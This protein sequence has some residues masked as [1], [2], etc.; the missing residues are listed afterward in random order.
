M[1]NVRQKYIFLLGWV[2]GAGS[3]C[4]NPYKDRPGVLSHARLPQ[5]S[6]W[7][8]FA[9]AASEFH[10]A[11]CLPMHSGSTWL[12]QTFR[13]SGNTRRALHLRL[14]SVVRRDGESRGTWI[15]LLAVSNRSFAWLP[16]RIARDDAMKS[17]RAQPPSKSMM[18]S[19]RSC[20]I[21]S[22]RCGIF[23]SFWLG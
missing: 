1:Y 23:L 9:G 20:A 12:D 8:T 7:Q 6:S 15:R 2:L 4:G 11:R 14:C 21:R 16:S 13:F 18:V 3:R 19:H 17:S 22:P 5:D 10:V